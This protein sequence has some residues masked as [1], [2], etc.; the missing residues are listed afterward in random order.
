MKI[1]IILLLVY[2]TI[3]LTSC[4][5]CMDCQST[6]DINLSVEYYSSNNGLMSLDTTT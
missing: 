3:L 5:D 2:L 4:M 1:K 6:T